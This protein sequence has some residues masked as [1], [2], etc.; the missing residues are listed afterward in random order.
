VR[1]RL[2]PIQ[3]ELSTAYHP[4]TDGQSEIFN[5]DVERHLRTF[6]TYQ[7]DN[8]SL[9]LPMAGFALRIPAK[10]MFDMLSISYA[11]CEAL[12]NME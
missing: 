3:V 10:S 1:R 6:V 7:Q 2:L 9:W 11:I 12:R 4:E 5:S 8:W